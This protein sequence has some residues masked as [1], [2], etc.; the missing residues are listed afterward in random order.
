MKKEK[1]TQKKLKKKKK[2]LNTR[3]CGF[4]HFFMTLI[5]IYG[6]LNDDDESRVGKKILSLMWSEVI[7]KKVKHHKKI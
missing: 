6:L 3:K 4:F 1:L 2:M 5:A 7:V